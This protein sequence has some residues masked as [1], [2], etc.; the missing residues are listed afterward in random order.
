MRRP[1][2]VNRAANANSR[3]FAGITPTLQRMGHPR[4]MTGQLGQ[5]RGAYHG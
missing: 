5:Q 3:K 4:D 1:V 2:N